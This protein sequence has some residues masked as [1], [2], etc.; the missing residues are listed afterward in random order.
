MNAALKLLELGLLPDPL[1]RAGIRAR[2]KAKL[3]TESEGGV[4]GERQRRKLFL[5]QVLDSPIAI[6][7]ED[8][9]QQHYELPSE[10]FLHVLGPNLKYSSGLWNEGISDIGRSEEDMLALTIERAELMDGHRILELGCG[11]GSLSLYMAARYPQSLI[12]VVSNS[13]TQ[14][15]FIE[16]RM[17]ERGLKNLTVIT[18]EMSRFEQPP[19]YDRVVSVEMFEHMRNYP[20]LFE[21]VAGFIKPGG[22]LFVHVFTHQKYAYFYD[23]QD[24]DDWIAKYFFTGGTMPSN[25]LFGYFQDHL[26][27]DEQWRVP[28]THYQ[29]TCRAWL[30]RMDSRKPDLMPIFED[31]YGSHARKWWNYWR[32]FFMSCEELFGY[33]GGSEWM[34]SHYRFVKK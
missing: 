11:W 5:R 26:R 18:S 16:A 15:E 23:A 31:V 8:A 6:H 3:E 10:F 25:D 17:A 30:H 29:K 14:K 12:T 22:K 9:N 32:V 24:P 7:T 27:L 20:K 1:I 33:R 4:E 19:I 28:G 21:R 34:V 2:L 13:R